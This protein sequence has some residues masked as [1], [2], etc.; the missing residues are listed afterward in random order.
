MQTQPIELAPRTAPAAIVLG[1]GEG[2]A[3]WFLDNLITV[4][5]R[6]ADGASFGVVESRLPAGSSTPFHRHD[7]EDEAVYVLEGELTLFLGGGRTH[8]VGPGSYVCF[9]R[10]VAH[11]LRA[12]TTTRLLVLS[13][14]AGFVEMIREAGA[15]AE[16]RELPPPAAP[17]IARLEAAC[18]RHEIALL[19]PLPE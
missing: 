14:P 19:G 6:S 1:P 5:S 2:E 15:P 9:P 11:G 13:D 16:R 17:D 4:K 18:A 3:V 12:E 10:G 7:G 8:R